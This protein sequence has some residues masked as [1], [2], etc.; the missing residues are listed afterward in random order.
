MRCDGRSRHFSGACLVRKTRPSL[1]LLSA[2]VAF[3]GRVI[4]VRQFSIPIAIPI[5]IIPSDIAAAHYGAIAR[6]SSLSCAIPKS[7]LPG[8]LR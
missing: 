4:A 3:V 5:A 6:L 1:T 8:N 7:Q 2:G